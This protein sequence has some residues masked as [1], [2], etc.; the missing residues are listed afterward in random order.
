MP[1]LN[2]PDVDSGLRRSDHQ[3]LL[4]DLRRGHHARLA[5]AMERQIRI[6]KFYE[7]SDEVHARGGLGERIMCVD[8]VIYW[9]M[10]RRYGVD[11]W[12]DKGFRQDMMRDE[13]SLRVRSRPRSATVRVNGLRQGADARTKKTNGGIVLP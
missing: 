5:L 6:A 3:A 4:N 1:I 2:M 12:A 13:P 9:E 7:N 11:C 10:V 8:A